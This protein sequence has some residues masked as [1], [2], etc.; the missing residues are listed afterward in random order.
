MLKRKMSHL[1]YILYLIKDIEYKVIQFFTIGI[2]P[3]K[4]SKLF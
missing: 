2:S 1:I 4:L 3:V